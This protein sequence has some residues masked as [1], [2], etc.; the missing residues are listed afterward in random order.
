MDRYRTYWP[1]T[2]RLGAGDCFT[3]ELATLTGALL[4]RT[5]CVCGL[6][7]LVPYGAVCCPLRLFP[8]LKC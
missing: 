3:R 2:A 5:A 6:G 7:S 1:V 4:M 8:I